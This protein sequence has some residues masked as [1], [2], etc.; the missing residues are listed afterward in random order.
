MDKTTK[1]CILKGMS[2]ATC[3]KNSTYS[4]T[5]QQ[6]LIIVIRTL[7]DG[8]V[9][10]VMIWVHMALPGERNITATASYPQI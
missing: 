4:N 6:N 3:P 10:N 5:N 7:R 2:K 9:A 1:L 8:L